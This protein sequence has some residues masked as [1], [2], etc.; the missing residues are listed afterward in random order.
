MICFR[1]VEFSLAFGEEVV[2]LAQLEL[3]TVSVEILRHIQFYLIEW[4][5]ERDRWLTIMYFTLFLLWIVVVV[6]NETRQSTVD[7]C[8]Y[9]KVNLIGFKSY[10]ISLVH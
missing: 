10:F 8:K 6:A 5:M 9:L 7:T 1:G 4:S 3:N 2:P